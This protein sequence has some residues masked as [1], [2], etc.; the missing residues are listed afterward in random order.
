MKMYGVVKK[1]SGRL[2]DFK[3]FKNK[4]N[5]LNHKN[6]YIYYGFPR[7]KDELEVMEFQLNPEEPIFQIGFSDGENEELLYFPPTNLDGTM[8]YYILAREVFQV[9]AVRQAIKV[10]E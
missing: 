4:F 1:N 6:G 9:E 5:A 8:V 3:L 7:A 2:M 10:K